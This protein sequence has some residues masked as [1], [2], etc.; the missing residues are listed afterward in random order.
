MKSNRRR[1]FLVA[2]LT[3]VTFLTAIT[4]RSLAGVSNWLQ[5]GPMASSSG[6][7]VSSRGNLGRTGVFGYE[8]LALTGTTLQSEKLFEMERERVFLSTLQETRMSDGSYVTSPGFTYR[9]SHG[10]YFSEP[11]VTNNTAYFTLF[12]GDSYLY[13]INAST[14]A[15]T[16]VIKRPK[17]RFS[18]PA[19]AGDK[20]FVGAD[21]GLFYAI[22]LKTQKELWRNQVPDLSFV[23]ASPSVKDGVVYFGRNN[24][25]FY[26]L[27]AQ[28]GAT[29]WTFD[30]M[31]IRFLSEPA[32]DKK[33]IYCASGTTIFALDTKTG[34]TEWTAAPGKI[35]Y[36]LA[37]SNGILYVI[38]GEGMIHSLDTQTGKPTSN[39]Q[40][41]GKSAFVFA[42]SGNTMY[43]RGW[44]SHD[45]I[46]VDVDT[47]K[48]K[49]K[50]DGPRCG[51]PAVVGNQ[52]LTTCDDG[53]LYGLDA[54]TGKKV[55]ERG[56]FKP[57]LSSPTIGNGAIYFVSDDGRLH[58]VR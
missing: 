13:A 21:K 37:A 5:D 51:L 22:D 48:T 7:G 43:L 12:I 26:A 24:G 41:Y 39:S 28:T 25:V 14:G 38:D 23:T 57:H 50:F 44:K 52:I 49:W 27:N 2:S 53:K 34:K 54:T 47:T 3:V 17:G 45:L 1:L 56:K 32:I 36:Y 19:V 18:E 4:V 20:L 40:K 31:A 15:L 10:F 42:I 33:K 46:A 11:I 29:V 58:V 35:V 30:T 55:W 8:P 9:Q 16:W 6:D